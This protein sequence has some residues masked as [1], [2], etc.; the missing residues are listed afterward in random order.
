MKCVY[1]SGKL[2]FEGVNDGVYNLIVNNN[3]DLSLYPANIFT[4]VEKQIANR[5]LE[6]GNQRTK[7]MARFVFSNA[8][9]VNVND[10]MLVLPERIDEYIYSNEFELKETST[11]I[12]LIDKNITKG[13]VDEYDLIEK[14][15]KD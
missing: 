1:E 14:I 6:S 2:I 12:R 3:N 4:E 13:Q 10:G 15:L 7:R 5:V 9:S 8:E 11:H